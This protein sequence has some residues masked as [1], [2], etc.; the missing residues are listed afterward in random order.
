MIE[1]GSERADLEGREHR[2]LHRVVSPCHMKVTVLLLSVVFVVVVIEGFCCALIHLP[3]ELVQMHTR[4][5]FE[6]SEWAGICDGVAT[7]SAHLD[8][9]WTDKCKPRRVFFF[10]GSASSR[11]C[12]SVTRVPFFFAGTTSYALAL[13]DQS[14]SL[15][16]R[17]TTLP[18]SAALA[19]GCLGT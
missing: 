16:P 10:V 4:M 19:I 17:E 1:L 3:R 14:P 7:D 15:R 11:R 13:C 9:V 5:A 2:S 8:R 6:S 12:T 18:S